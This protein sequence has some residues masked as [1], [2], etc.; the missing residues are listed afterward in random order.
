MRLSLFSFVFALTAIL[1]AAHA[2]PVPEQTESRRETLAMRLDTLDT[3][4]DPLSVA[5]RLQDWL[6]DNGSGAFPPDFSDEDRRS[7][8]WDEP[9]Q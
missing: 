9:P 4:R 2:A 6:E 1:S 3:T 8:P 5:F 7:D